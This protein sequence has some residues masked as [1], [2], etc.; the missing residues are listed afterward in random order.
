MLAF[1]GSSGMK[2]SVLRVRVFVSRRAMARAN[3]GLI[4]QGLMWLE[5]NTG[6]NGCLDASSPLKRMYL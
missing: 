3:G 2:G 5:S 6:V 4:F 1:P